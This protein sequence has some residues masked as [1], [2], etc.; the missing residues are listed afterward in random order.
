MVSMVSDLRILAKVFGSIFNWLQ[1]RRS[2]IGNKLGIAAPVLVE[3]R[4]E[5]GNFTA[6]GDENLEEFDAS[7]T[8]E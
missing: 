5:E 2:G 8:F 7:D 3:F 1:R 4:D 6:F